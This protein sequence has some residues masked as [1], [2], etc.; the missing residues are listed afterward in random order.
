MPFILVLILIFLRTVLALLAFLSA[1]FLP[2]LPPTQAGFAQ[3]G[4]AAPPHPMAPGTTDDDYYLGR[5]GPART[6]TEAASTEAP[7]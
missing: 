7:S 4:M 2:D 3:P 5:V 1:E 6:D